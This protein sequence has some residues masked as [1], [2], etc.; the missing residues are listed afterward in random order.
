[1]YVSSSDRHSF[2]LLTCECRFVPA[3][4]DHPALVW[5]R[6]LSSIGDWTEQDHA[7]FPAPLRAIIATLLIL[8][9]SESPHTIMLSHG[10]NGAATVTLYALFRWI[11]RLNYFP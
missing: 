7:R 9:R 1:M 4:Y 6:T 3:F 8:A 2:N 10:L 5:R 11:G